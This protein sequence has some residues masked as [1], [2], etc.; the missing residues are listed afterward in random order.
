MKVVRV[1]VKTILLALFILFFTIPYVFYFIGDWG[2]RNLDKG[3]ENVG[4]Y[5]I[6]F[7]KLYEHNPTVK[8]N[9]V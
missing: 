3:N 5:T 6:G 2:Y 7:L 8:S 4:T 9:K 1:K